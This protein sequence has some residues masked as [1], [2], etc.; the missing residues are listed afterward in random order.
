MTRRGKEALQDGSLVQRRA[1]VVL[2]TNGRLASASGN[3][4]DGRQ[5]MSRIHALYKMVAIV[6]D[7]LPGGSGGPRMCR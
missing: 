3:C 1:P 6:Q 4:A 7:G 2:Q 5:G